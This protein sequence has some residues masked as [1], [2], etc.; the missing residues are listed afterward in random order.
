MQDEQTR[1]LAIQCAGE[2]IRV[3]QALGHDLEPILR[4]SPALWCAAADGQVAALAELE[5]GWKKWME[6]SKEPH[7]GSVGHDLVKGRRTEI[8]SMNGYIAAKGKELGIATPYNAKLVDVVLKV[9][10]GE[11]KAAPNILDE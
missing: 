7:Y 2:A 8:E 5:A 4:M 10:R 11:L 6:R 1:L 9:Q 3:A